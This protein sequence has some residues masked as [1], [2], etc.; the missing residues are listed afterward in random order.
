MPSV[1]PSSVV[2]GPSTVQAA[3]T[4]STAASTARRAHPRSETAATAR[5]RHSR[6]TPRRARRSATASSASEAA[7]SS[8][9]TTTSPSFVPVGDTAN[10]SAVRAT[11]RSPAVSAGGR[12]V[13]NARTERTRSPGNRC[14][15]AS[16]CRS[17]LPVPDVSSTRPQASPSGTGSR[18]TCRPPTSTISRPSAVLTVRPVASAPGMSVARTVAGPSRPSPART[19]GHGTVTRIDSGA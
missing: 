15:A 11:T 8:S 6:P 9:A 13:V 18:Y 16:P 12:S 19:T 10:Q 7:A 2:S 17:T 3:S 4:A 14:G 1:N 5:A